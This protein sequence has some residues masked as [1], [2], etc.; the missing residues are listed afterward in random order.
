LPA[1]K[2]FAIA[3]D[4]GGAGGRLLPVLGIVLGLMSR[5]ASAMD[6]DDEGDS[7]P[8]ARS[9]IAADNDQR[10]ILAEGEGCEPFNSGE[11]PFLITHWL[12]GFT[13]DAASRHGVTDDATIRSLRNATAT[14]ASAFEAIG[15]FGRRLVRL[16]IFL[17]ITSHFQ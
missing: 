13:A 1:L 7:K 12:D 8:A 17:L 3:H 6:L 5:P 16:L 14:L 4:S 15:S 10:S 11:I 2:D 9:P